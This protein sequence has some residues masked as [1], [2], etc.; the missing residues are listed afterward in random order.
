M[1]I[2]DVAFY[3]A[4]SFIAGALAAGLNL[5]A[6]KAVFFFAILALILAYVKIWGKFP[7]FFFI[8]FFVFGTFYYNFF[9]AI[10]ESSQ[11]I[12]F[13]KTVEFSGMITSEPQLNEKFQKATIELNPPFSGEISV[14]AP[15]Y[16]QINY[17]DV[18]EAKGEI[19][20][21]VSKNQSPVSFFPELKIMES[22]RGF[23]LKEKLLN[24]KKGMISQFRNLLPGDPAAL[25]SGMTLGWRGDFTEKFKKEMSLSGTTHIV[26]LSGYN[27]T[28]LV[29]AVAAVFGNWLSR[30]MTFFLTSFI[31]LL[32]IFMVGAE[33][34][35]VRAA[36]M[37]FIALIAKESGRRFSFRNAIAL[38]AAA[39]I[40]F[41]PDVLFDIGFIL[42]FLSLIG[43]IYIAPELKEI[44]RIGESGS[45]MS[46][47]ENAITTL[48]AQ[49]MVAPV[50]IN[51]FGNFSLTS[52][53]AN[54]LILEFVPLTMLLGFVIAVF[55]WI[56]YYAGFIFSVFGNILLRYEIG[57]IKFFAFWSMP[58]FSGTRSLIFSFF[59]YIALL[60]FLLYRKEI[61]SRELI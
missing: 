3:G 52:I 21:S 46:W 60:V 61:K 44:F 2:Y 19:R 28:I 34:S 1:P 8:F 40:L 27:I 50:L 17:G 58:V 14:L 49:M 11:K 31:I 18:I 32:F 26:A 15:L 37:G 29:I 5:S 41:R 12:T 25:L 55:G 53:A 6:A 39:M 4:L 54:V 43:I 30:R 20:P 57:V 16:P 9:F 13:E 7:A 38:T 48:S 22:H 35:V 42:S 24:I 51:V 33:E 45:F 10:K 47:K 36:I 59:Y 56:F 23:W